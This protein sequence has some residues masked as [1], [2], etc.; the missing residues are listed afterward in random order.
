MMK[1]RVVFCVGEIEDHMSNL[2][3]AQLL[4]LESENPEK[5]ISL[6][7]NS[8][9]GVV[10][11]GM[12]IHDTMQFIRAPVHTIAYGQA[13][14]MG[15]FLLASGEPGHRYSLPHTRVMIHQPSGGARGQATDIEIHAKEILRMKKEL[16]QKLAEYSAGKSTYEKLLDLM[17]RDKFLSPE[18]SLEL[19]LIDQIVSKRTDT[20]EK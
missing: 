17:E 7:I 15:S 20:T 4:F 10:T 19:G 18:E 9:G 12:A 3:V 16:T 13:A 8:P 2:I 5:P 1:D 14:S 6:Y 11:A